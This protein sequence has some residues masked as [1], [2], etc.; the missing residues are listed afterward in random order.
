[1]YSATQAVNSTGIIA[2]KPYVNSEYA[3]EQLNSLISVETSVQIN[4]DRTTRKSLDA[5]SQ[6]QAVI[7]EVFETLNLW[8]YS[9]L[10]CSFSLK[11]HIDCTLS[12][13]KITE[14]MPTLK[15]CFWCT[16]FDICR[17]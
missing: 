10:L 12:D 6:F 1:M 11:P 7:E 3:A 2:I 9:E 4:Y 5:I 8:R 14:E 17:N 15:K 13:L 16:G